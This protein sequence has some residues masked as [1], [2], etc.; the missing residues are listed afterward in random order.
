MI[1]VIFEYGLNLFSCLI[2]L[3]FVDVVCYFHFV[4]FDYILKL[5]VFKPYSNKVK[6]RV[7]GWKRKGGKKNQRRLP[8]KKIQERE[9][10][11]EWRKMYNDNILEGKV[12]CIQ[13]GII[14]QISY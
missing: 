8:E 3:C 10:V 12:Y 11:K 2:K 13:V 9:G 6:S 5:K 1:L 7:K 14:Y 4:V